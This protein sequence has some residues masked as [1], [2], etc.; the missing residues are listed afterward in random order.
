MSIKQFN[1][2]YFLNE[3]R[4]IFRF[5][6]IDN[7]EYKFWLT[8][9]LTHFILKSAGQFLEKQHDE[10]SSPSVE[11]IISELQQQSDKQAPNF[12]TSYESG[13]QYPFG[14][15]AVLVMDIKCEMTKIEEHDIFSLDFIL[16]G[17]G[18]MNLQLTAPIMQNLILLLEELNIQANW[19]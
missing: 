15:D 7:S 17:G 8:R 16:P 18:N 11:K 19:R 9:R 10:K 14:A 2:T 6:T 13:T 1:A 3:D 4:I 5:N 12:S